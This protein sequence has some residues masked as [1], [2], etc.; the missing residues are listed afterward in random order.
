MEDNRTRCIS[1][2]RG[3]IRR[4]QYRVRASTGEQNIPC[5]CA[6]ESEW[7]IRIIFGSACV[8]RPEIDSSRSSPIQRQIPVRVRDSGVCGARSCG[9][10]GARRQSGGGRD[11]PGARIPGA[12]VFEQR[13]QERSFRSRADRR[14]LE[15]EME[16]MRDRTRKRGRPK[17]M[18]M[19]SAHLIERALTLE[20]HRFEPREREARTW[21]KLRNA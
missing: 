11:A 15:Q 6:K 5:I 19:N 4:A 12:R 9:A 1:L 2:W 8:R 10:I 20:R 17:Y 21:S 7:R 14:A 3:H 16:S 13:L 18:R